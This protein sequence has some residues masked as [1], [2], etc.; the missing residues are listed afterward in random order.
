MNFILS[1]DG[2]LVN[3]EQVVCFKKKEEG[4]TPAT[5]YSLVCVDVDRNE[6]CIKKFK[7]GDYSGYYN[8]FNKFVEKFKNANIVFDISSLESN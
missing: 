8:F 2:E 7:K 5:N 1:A 4:G 6:Y 3:L